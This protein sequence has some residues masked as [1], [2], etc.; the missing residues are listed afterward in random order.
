MFSADHD[1]FQEL[2]KSHYIKLYLYK[3]YT[4]YM[5]IHIYIYIYIYIRIYTTVDS[6]DNDWDDSTMR[7]YFTAG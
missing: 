3:I 6:D 1:V 2:N 4:T 5:Y 7:S